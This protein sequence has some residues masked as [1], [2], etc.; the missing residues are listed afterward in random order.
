MGHIIYWPEVKGR[1]IMNRLMLDAKIREWLLEDMNNG[2]ITSDSLLTENEISSGVFIAKETGILAGAEVAERVFAILDEN[3]EIKF[4]F[5][6]GTRVTKG[7]QIARI[8]GETR[9]ILKG[10]RLALNLLQRLSGIA[11]QTAMFVEQVKG[12][13][14][15]IAD[16]RKTTPGLRF[17]EKYAVTVGGGYNHRFNLSESVMLKDNHIAA[18]GSI[19]EAVR[20]VRSAVSHTIRIEV[21]VESL[22]QLEEALAAKADIIM[23]DNMSVAMMKEAVQIAGGRAVLEASGNV[24]IENVR[25]VAETG[26]DVISIGSI[27]HSVKALDISLRFSI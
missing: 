3:I 8:Q 5:K 1:M 25:S 7:D 6:D 22:E 2:D 4:F 16:T 12:L 19:S 18:C 26:V 14:V 9:N 13:P 24:G 17:L 27:T 23:L 11:T 15:R 20:R 10:E 21:E